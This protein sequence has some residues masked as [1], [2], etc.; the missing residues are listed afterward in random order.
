[1]CFARPAARWKGFGGGRSPN[2]ISHIAA[3]QSG[4]MMM[5]PRHEFMLL[6]YFKGFEHNVATIRYMFITLNEASSRSR[7]NDHIA[8]FKCSSP[9]TVQRFNRMMSGHT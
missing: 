4:M 5:P 8:T 3:R 6:V 7:F 9:A 1:M 2:H